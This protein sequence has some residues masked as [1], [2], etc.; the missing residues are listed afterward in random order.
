MRE[1][2]PYKRENAGVVPPEIF[3]TH[4]EIV[5]RLQEVERSNLRVG[6]LLS[7]CGLVLISAGMAGRRWNQRRFPAE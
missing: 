7:F 3:V 4:A 2:N 5:T 1:D 6:G